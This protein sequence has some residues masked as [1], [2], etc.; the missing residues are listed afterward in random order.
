METDVRLSQRSNAH[1]PIEV[2]ELVM[3][4]EIKLVQERNAYSP[5]EV[6]ELGI[7]KS[8]VL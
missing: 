2:T 8:V 7:S 5:I 4:I 1:L 3:E 6:T